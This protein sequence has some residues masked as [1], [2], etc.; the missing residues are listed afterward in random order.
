MVEVIKVKMLYKKVKWFCK[1]LVPFS[2]YSE[3]IDSNGISRSCSWRM[4]MGHSFNI[5]DKIR[6]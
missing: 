6:G 4:W 2:Y 5:E 1:Q 3:Y